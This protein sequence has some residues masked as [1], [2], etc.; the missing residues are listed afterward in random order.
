MKDIMVKDLMKKREIMKYCFVCEI[1]VPFYV[2][3][4]SDFYFY[5]NIKMT[6]W[7]MLWGKEIWA[8]WNDDF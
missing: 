2:L 7:D 6:I 4:K 5:N 1:S 8:P 3:Y